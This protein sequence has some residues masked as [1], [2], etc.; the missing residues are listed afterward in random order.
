MAS[1]LVTGAG[2]F[3]GAAVVEALA[4]RGDAVTAVDLVPGARLAQIAARYGTVTA[5][6]GEVTEWGRMAE[7]VQAARPQAIVHCAAVVGVPASVQAPFRTFQ[8]NVEGSLNLLEAMRLLGVRRMVHLSSEETYG[9]FTAPAVAETHPQQPLMPY[10]ISKLAVELLGRSYGELYGLECL[11]VRASWVYGPGL[12]RA[13]IPKT[14]V[15][16]AL[17]GR[18]LHLPTG[19]DFAVD[20]TYVDDVVAGILAVLDHDAHPY[21]AYNIGSGEAP[22]LGEIVAM[23][24]ELVPGA[25]LSV[26]PGDYLHAGELPAVRKGALDITR[27]RTVLGYAPRY[28]LRAGLAATIAALRAR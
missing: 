9:P 17:A 3:L 18:P 13:R 20:H 26:G 4:A 5:H 16:A 12:P 8:V 21:D 10:G 11:N 24:K 15:D 14:L 22:T 23:V 6:A 7:L 19:A 1:I 27:A 25:E 28:D 2:G